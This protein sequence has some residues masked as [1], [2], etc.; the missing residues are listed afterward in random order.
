M[1]LVDM[2]MHLAA[3]GSEVDP[4]QVESEVFAELG[5]PAAI[6]PIMRVTHFMHAFSGDA[7]AAATYAY[8]WSDVLA[9]DAAEAFLQAPGGLYDAPTAERYRTAF[10]SVG[11][12]VPTDEAYRAFR[13]RDPDPE[14]LAR[15]FHLVPA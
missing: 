10:L 3:D 15:R 4:Q 13:G 5:L 11:N 1:A 14:A 9:A 2:R 12:R 7:Y 6:D 8:L